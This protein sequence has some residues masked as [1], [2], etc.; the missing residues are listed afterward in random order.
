M[1]RYWSLAMEG[2]PFGL[3]YPSESYARD[4]AK[5]VLTVHADIERV[6]ILEISTRS[7]GYE[8]RKGPLPNLL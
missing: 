6:E 5:K 4:A 8:A 3:R 7:L 1:A 2:V